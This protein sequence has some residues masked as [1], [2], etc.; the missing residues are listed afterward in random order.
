MTTQNSNDDNAKNQIVTNPKKNCDNSKTKIV[1][2]KKTLIV[3]V[4]TQ[5]L[6]LWPNKNCEKKL[7]N[8]RSDTIEKK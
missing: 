5:K 3:N 7:K 6:K 2:K 8:L 1:K 4:T